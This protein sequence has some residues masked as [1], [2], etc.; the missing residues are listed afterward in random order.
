MRKRI[1][2]HARVTTIV[3]WEIVLHLAVFCAD[4]VAF[5]Y[6]SHESELGDTMQDVL[7]IPRSSISLLEQV[8]LPVLKTWLW[9]CNGAYDWA[10]HRGLEDLAGE[11]DTLDLGGDLARSRG[12]LVAEQQLG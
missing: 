8:E 9:D 6:P 7:M 4:P 11:A 12:I 5:M 3:Q 2:M 1:G 10:T